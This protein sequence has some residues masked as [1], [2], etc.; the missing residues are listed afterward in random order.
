MI[1][2]DRYS[3]RQALETLNQVYYL[4]HLYVNFFQPA[5]KLVSKSRQGARVHKVYDTAKTPYQRLQDLDVLT[6]AKK[7][8]LATSYARLNPAKL[9]KQINQSLEHLWTLKERTITLSHRIN[10]E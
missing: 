1:G 2:Y 3:S 9:L 6:E 7:A 4:L 5:M 8:E 10:Q